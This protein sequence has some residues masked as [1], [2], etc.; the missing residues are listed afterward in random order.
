MIFQNIYHAGR[1]LKMTVRAHKNQAVSI[2]GRATHLDVLAAINY[3]SLEIKNYKKYCSGVLEI[4]SKASGFNHAYWFENSGTTAVLKFQWHENDQ[5][6][7]IRENFTDPIDY[8][9][10]FKNWHEKLSSGEC[11]FSSASKF[12]NPQKSYFEKHGILSTAAL[13]LFV[14]DN[15]FGF[16]RLDSEKT[17]KKPELS[18]RRLLKAAATSV[19]VAL[20]QRTFYDKLKN[21]GHRH[22]DKN[23]NAVELSNKTKGFKKF[24]HRY[25]EL[26]SNVHDIVYTTDLLGNITSINRYAEVVTGYKSL[27]LLKA[28]FEDHIKPQYKPLFKKMLQLIRAGE[29]HDTKFE[30]EIN[31]KTGKTLFLEVSNYIVYNEG[32]P[33]EIFGVAHDIT[34]RKLYEEQLKKNDETLTGVLN[35]SSDAVMA[36]SSLRDASGKIIDFEC[37]IIN[38]PAE[39]LLGR[40]KFEIKGKRLLA[41]MRGSGIEELFE[42]FVQV[43]ETGLPLFYEHHY[44]NSDAAMW[45][46]ISAKRLFDGIVI[47]LSD[48]TYQKQYEKEL[49]EQLNFNE[50]LLDNLPYPAILINKNRRIL[51]MNYNAGQLGAEIDRYC[52]GFMGHKEDLAGGER[53][54]HEESGCFFCKLEKC[55]DERRSACCSEICIHEKTWELRLLHVYEDIFLFYAI[56]TTESKMIRTELETARKDSKK[57]ETIKRNFLANMSHE[58]RTPMNIIMGFTEILSETRLE[59]EQLEFL[60]HIQKSSEALLSIINDI[61]DYSN[62]EA[63]KLEVESENFNIG[64]VITE[65]IETYR[66]QAEKKGIGIAGSLDPLLKDDLIGDPQRLKQVLLNLLNNALKFSEKGTVALNIIKESEES[67]GVF[68]KFEIIDE[69]IGISEEQQQEMFSPFTQADSTIT[70]SY[71]GLGLGLTLANHLVR[72]MGGRR[73]FI[74]SI[75]GLGSNFYFSLKFLKA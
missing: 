24:E 3:K 65:V 53:A 14:S 6:G 66:N 37:G 41:D 42:K 70:R 50:I 62:I 36:F 67:D 39:R 27:E 32:E 9:I 43:V 44:G 29:L 49:Q 56:D 57:V 28:N 16:I 20:T 34:E 51:A 19:C 45:L 60:K 72:I 61:I 11:L 1:N 18:R 2:S 71:G 74:E 47:N 35:N 73:I 5:K 13:P 17:E 10:S 63:E 52:W 48:V 64:A 75:P 23:A 38:L 59:G 46:R 25:N 33:F 7:L 15:F 4:L 58:L 26:F 30:I 55:I 68:V 40:K 21:A 31:S 12:S 8:K 22:V 54:A 69:G